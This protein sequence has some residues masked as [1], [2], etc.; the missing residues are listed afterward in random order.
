MPTNSHT[1]GDKFAPKAKKCIMLG[2]PS[3]QKAYRVYDLESHKLMVCRDVVF[4]QNIFPFKITEQHTQ[5]GYPLLFHP[6]PNTFDED[7]PLLVDEA[8][9]DM[10]V[11]FQHEN[12]TQ[13]SPAAPATTDTQS[14]VHSEN[15]APRSVPEVLNLRRSERARKLP[16]KFDD[17]VHQ[18]TDA[19][20]TDS[21]SG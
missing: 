7:P 20:R 3:G 6:Q 14:S 10:D 11:P 19:S 1:K 4:K 16:S 12:P 5:E 17:Y 13:E 2:Y 21:S 15:A 9:N 8:V 18:I